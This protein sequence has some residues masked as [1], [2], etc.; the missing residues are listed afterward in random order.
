MGPVPSSPPSRPVGGWLTGS[1]LWEAGRRPDPGLSCPEK[2][3][4]T[5]EGWH[6]QAAPPAAALGARRRGG[7]GCTAK[8]WCPRQSA[9]S[10]GGLG[11]HLDLPRTQPESRL[12]PHLLLLLCGFQT[13]TRP[14]WNQQG[15]P[16]RSTVTSWA[17]KV[18]SAGA[19][20]RAEVRAGVGAEAS[21]PRQ[22]RA[23][24]PGEQGAGQGGAC[25]SHSLTLRT[26]PSLVPTA[27]LTRVI[28][29]AAAWD[30]FLQKGRHGRGPGDVEAGFPPQVPECVGLRRAGGSGCFHSIGRRGVEVWVFPAQN[31]QQ[32]PSPGMFHLLPCSPEPP[33]ARAEPKDQCVGSSAWGF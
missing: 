27:E 3:S 29:H 17:P 26:P 20:V 1:V 21:A 18:P 30:V 13:P 22:S 23:Q 28:A 25:S 11:S 15:P 14:D 5:Q 31:S 8:G 9:W 6:S 16:P 32:C 12:F 19:E 24:C 33:R 10:R 4:Q 7:H 2:R